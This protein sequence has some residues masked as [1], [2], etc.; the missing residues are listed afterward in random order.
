MTA[1]AMQARPSHSPRPNADQVREILIVDDHPLMCDALALTLKI[2][3]GLK[4]V[5]TARSLGAAVEQI[6]SQGAPDAVIL[7]LN[8]PDARGAEGIVALRRQLPDVPITMISADLEGAMI[9]AAM[10]AGA[11]G[12]ISKSLSREA[13]V[14]SLRRMWDGEHVTPE[15]YE[16][17]KAGAEDEAK[18]ELARRF[19]TLTPQQMRILRLI[20][21]GK[22]NK[23]ISYELSIAEATVKTHITAI[24]SKINARRRT[25]A[26]LLANSVRLFEAG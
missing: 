10:A 18:A 24:M 2:S 17:G 19:A 12:Y 22:A 9:S 11:Q 26:V 7:D 23:E 3:F 16:P 13:L 20:C 14:D 4:N 25:Q 21:Q 15:G 1:A 5:R 6:K 8:L